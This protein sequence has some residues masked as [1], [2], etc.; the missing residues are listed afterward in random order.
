MERFLKSQY[1]GFKLNETLSSNL[2]FSG[3]VTLRERQK[4]SIPERD[5]EYYSLKDEFGA[6]FSCWDCKLAESLQLFEKYEVSGEIKISKGATF[7]NLK[8]AEIFNGRN[9]E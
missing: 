2:R 3:V 5:V 9:Y 1:S 4:I 6:R 8:R 7:L